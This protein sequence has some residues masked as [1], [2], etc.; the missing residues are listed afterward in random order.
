MGIETAP[1]QFTVHEVSKSATNT[2]QLSATKSSRPVQTAKAAE[3]KSMQ[4]LTYQEETGP[5]QFSVHEV[6]KSGNKTSLKTTKTKSAKPAQKVQKTVKTITYGENGEVVD[7]AHQEEQFTVHEMTKS[8]TTT[9]LR[10]G[11]T[12]M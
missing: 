4:T 3:L 10:G 7:E 1:E 12:Q 9:N 8:H 6:T 5:E 2:N 11:S